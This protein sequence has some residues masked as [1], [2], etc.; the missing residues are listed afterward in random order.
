MITGMGIAK[1]TA[2][3]AWIVSAAAVANVAINIVLI[4]IWGMHAAA[5]TTVLA[6]VVMVV[7]SW[8]YSQKVYPIAYDWAR[9]I[10]TAVIGA[11]L[12]A[13]VVYLTPGEGL[14]GIVAASV[15]WVL[16]VILLVKTETISRADVARVRGYI[17]RAL[18]GARRWSTR[19]RVA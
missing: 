6:N 12:V 18:Q 9:I 19:E 17:R 15:A 5:V 7:G 4:P 2:P 16:Y 11:V 3:M 10:R 14:V 8:Y 13:A 1:K